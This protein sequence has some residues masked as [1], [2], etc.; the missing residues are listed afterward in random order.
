MLLDNADLSAYQ[1]GA[2]RG[3]CAVK[4]LDCVGFV[5]RNRSAADPIK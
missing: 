2:A 4:C 5:D 1:H 3:L